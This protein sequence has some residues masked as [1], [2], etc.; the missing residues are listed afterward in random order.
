M[1][2][3]ISFALIYPFYFSPSEQSRDIPLGVC[4]IKSKLRQMGYASRVFDLNSIEEA[5]KHYFLSNISSIKSFILDENGIEKDLLKMADHLGLFDYDVICFSVYSFE[6]LL[7]SLALSKA[8]KKRAT[9]KK[10]VFGGSFCEQETGLLADF[11]FVDFIIRGIGEVGIESLIKILNDCGTG[12]EYKNIIY[13]TSDFSIIKA[14]LEN[15]IDQMSLPD[16]TDLDLNN[17]KDGEGRLE[18][19]YCVGTGCTNRC[20]YCSSHRYSVPAYK[21]PKKVGEDIKYLRDRYHAD[22]FFLIC[23][24]F[25]ISEEYMQGIAG[26]LTG[27]G[28]TWATCITYKNISVKTLDLMKKSGCIKLLIGVETGSQRLLNAMNKKIDLKSIRVLEDMK[29]LGIGNRINIILDLPGETREDVLET[30]SLLNKH[31]KFI[32]EARFILFELNKGTYIFEHPNEFGIR[33]IKDENDFFSKYVYN[34]LYVFSSN[35]RMKASGFENYPFYDLIKPFLQKSPQTKKENSAR[36]RRKILFYYHHFGGYGHGMR[37]FSICKAL[38][39]IGKFK[40]LVV[41]SGVPQPELGIDRYAKVY[42]LPALTAAD[43]LFKGL[44][45]NEDIEKAMSKRKA[46][47]KT[48]AEK[49]APDVAVIE[50][51]PFG[52]MSLKDEIVGFIQRLK[53]KKCSVYSSVRDLILSTGRKEYFDLFNAIL[54]HD[55]HELG[56]CDNQPPNSLFTGR[57]HPYD[58]IILKQTGTVKTRAGNSKKVIVVSIGGGLD[59]H[60]LLEKIVNIRARISQKIPSFM[61]VF[62]GHAFP[63]DHFIK[64]QKRLDEDSQIARFDPDIMKHVAEADL[65]ISM[66]GYN[67]INSQLLTKAPSMIFP[68]L[69]DKEQWERAKRYGFKCYD[70]Q[71]MSEQDL[72]REICSIL[73]SPV[74][75]KKKAQMNGAQLTARF[76]ERAMM[77]KEAKIR[78]TTKCN[79]ACSMC[80]WKDRNEQLD[81]K[82]VYSLLDDLAMLSVKTV[83][84][85]GGE[86]AVYPG[87]ERLVQY[88]KNKGF[89]VSLSTNGF[90]QSV[91]IKILKFL[92]AV[93]ISMDSHLETLNDVIR[94]RKGAFAAAM[95]SIHLCADNGIKPHINVTVRP[96]NYRGIHKIFSNLSDRISSISFTLVDTT[97]NRMEEL[98]FSRK[99]LEAYYGREVPAILRDSIKFDVFIRIVPFFPNFFQMDSR[100]ILADFLGHKKEYLSRLSE[101]FTLNASDC[102]RAKEQ[103]RINAN[104][105]ASSCC[106]LDDRRTAF[107]NI[108]SMSL[109]DILIGDNYFNHTMNAKEGVGVCSICRQGYTRYKSL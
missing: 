78:I 91:L 48:I 1:S 105:D 59:G 42:N 9:D 10:T 20:Y 67:S 3:Q 33:T 23:N 51:F 64:L 7:I 86:P 30:V 41:N 11:P 63:D 82:K 85:T 31:E 19:P 69:S 84:F 80:S 96:D 81:E 37:I 49:F 72:S 39:K 34:H 62:T 66:G 24:F 101:I 16:F 12:P 17:Y 98:Q 36:S 26:E 13:R 14:P 107:G 109:K 45:A 22:H 88:A 29:K 76:F 28:V 5:V 58:D 55:D 21:N 61:M 47:L 15:E 53:D 6:Q 75:A 77:L 108:N 106:Y 52:R 87:L 97:V 92:D 83:N 25:N 50:H 89:R 18:I 54:I 79:L 90:D 46:L 94:G 70:Y 27:L 2:K 103:V 60:E 56:S 4:Q 99:E 71:T 38:E 8:I 32:D 93:D 40:I 95:K 35:R 100:K 65:F 73:S 74:E 102:V 104:G 43:E 44:S 68:R 57:V